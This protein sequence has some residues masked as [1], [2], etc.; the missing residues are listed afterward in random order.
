LGRVGIQTQKQP[1]QF[2]ER[3]PLEGFAHGRLRFD[4]REQQVIDQRFDVETGA[5]D[6]DRQA[7]APDDAPDGDQGLVAPLGHGERLERIQEIHHVVRDAL[8]HECALAV[9]RPALAPGLPRPDIE[10]FVDLARISVY[11][12]SVEGFGETQTQIRLA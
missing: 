4:M 7:L 2:L 11:D 9:E 5:A 12:L 1:H 10:T 8:D 6:D 3:T